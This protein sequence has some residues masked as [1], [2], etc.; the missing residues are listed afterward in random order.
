[1]T[2]PHSIKPLGMADQEIKKTNHICG[3]LDLYA[4]VRHCTCIYNE[5]MAG[6]A[7]EIVLDSGEYLPLIAHAT[8]LYEETSIYVV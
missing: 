2:P 5:S 1:M 3:T 7:T 4:I 6:H 8:G